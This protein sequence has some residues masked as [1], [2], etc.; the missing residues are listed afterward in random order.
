MSVV[1]ECATG[2]GG[3]GD[4]ADG[5]RLGGG[6]CRLLRRVQKNPKFLRIFFLKT[7]NVKMST[8]KKRSVTLTLRSSTSHHHHL[9]TLSVYFLTHMISQYLSMSERPPGVKYIVYRILLLANFNAYVI[10][11]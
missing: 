8:R 1:V 6:S 9:V 5:A 11:T 7:L 10:S 2:G 3:R 4:G